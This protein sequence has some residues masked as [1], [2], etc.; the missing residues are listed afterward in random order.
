MGFLAWP[1]RRAEF[2]SEILLLHRIWHWN[3]PRS[4]D[5]HLQA[6]GGLSTP[7]LS[8]ASSQFFRGLLCVPGLVNVRERRDRERRGYEILLEQK[9]ESTSPI[10]QATTNFF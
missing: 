6:D 8:I 5:R 7:C 2:L 4:S 9:E 10:D 3:N 1:S